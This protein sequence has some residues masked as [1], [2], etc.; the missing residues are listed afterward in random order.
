VLQIVVKQPPFLSQI[1]KLLL[2]YEL[3]W[4]V[5]GGGWASVFK[6]YFWPRP[7]KSSQQFGKQ[8]A[9]VINVELLCTG[10]VPQAA[11]RTL[12]YGSFTFDPAGL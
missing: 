9:G 4:C 7:L 12:K 6:H 10:R 5:G 11:N 3:V 1:T 8:S 2:M